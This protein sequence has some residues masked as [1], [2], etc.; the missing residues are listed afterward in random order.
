MSQASNIGLRSIAKLEIE[1]V[2][3]LM[4]GIFISRCWDGIAT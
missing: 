1:V 4:L 2:P 3:P